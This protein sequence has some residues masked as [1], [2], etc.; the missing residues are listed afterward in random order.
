MRCMLYCCV[1]SRD[2]KQESYTVRK[3]KDKKF[4]LYKGNQV[5]KRDMKS[6]AEAMESL[7]EELSIMVN[8]NNGGGKNVNYSEL[9]L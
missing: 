9:E 4:F 5:I 2:N 6:I 8:L 1:G 7:T 3:S